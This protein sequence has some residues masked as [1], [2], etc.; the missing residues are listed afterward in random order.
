MMVQGHSFAGAKAPRPRAYFDD[1][2]GRFM[3]ENPWGRDGSAMDFL[4]VGGT[5]AAGSDLDQQLAR[6][7]AGTGMVS[8][9]RS[10]G[11]R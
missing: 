7:D 8:K 6:L 10:S 1:G 5:D 9:R 3:P 2:S 4:D 11:P